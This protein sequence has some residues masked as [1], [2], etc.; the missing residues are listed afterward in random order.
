MKLDK[1]KS[2]G[3]LA[4]EGV[5][6]NIEDGLEVRVARMNNPRYREH[7]RK[8]T[9]TRLKHGR[10]IP[11]GGS[12]VS[13]DMLLELQ[14]RAVATN[15]LIDWKG[16]EDSDGKEIKYSVEEALKIFDSHPDF[17]DMII[18]IAQD[19]ELFRGEDLAGAEENS[20][21]TSPGTSSGEST[22]SS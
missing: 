16:L 22:E 1:F 21:P 13:F 5:W 4:L 3:Q 20:S 6:E 8:L 14:Q 9:R 19:V 12:D 7:L 17:Y 18:E 10:R 15:I 2:D 11:G